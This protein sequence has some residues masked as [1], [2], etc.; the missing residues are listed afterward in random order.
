MVYT[1]NFYFWRFWLHNVTNFYLTI[2]QCLCFM[3]VLSINIYSSGVID[4]CSDT[5]PP[6]VNPNKLFI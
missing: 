4:K 1:K 6:S 3:A 5:I 2:L